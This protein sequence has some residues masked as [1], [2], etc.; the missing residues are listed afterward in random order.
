MSEDA[1]FSLPAKW[2]VVIERRCPRGAM[3]TGLA[4]AGADIAILDCLRKP[5]NA[6]ATA[7]A[8]LGRQAIGVKC[9]ATR[10]ADLEKVW[11]GAG[12][13]GHVVYA[14]QCAGVNSATPF[15]EI[16]EQEWQRIIDI[17]LKSVFLACRY[18]QGHGGSGHGAPSSTSHRLRPDRLCR[19]CSPTRGPREG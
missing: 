8:A 16:P 5:R 9:D 18:R 19:R 2:R 4:E 3:A 7:I 6:R 17:N 12:T 13:L 14:H 15:F 11:H 1:L 10:K